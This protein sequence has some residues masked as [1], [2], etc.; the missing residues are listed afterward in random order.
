MARPIAK[1]VTETPLMKQY[2]EMKQKHPD[3][4]L[5]FHVGDFTRRSRRMP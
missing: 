3:A 2:M 5:L 1:K 4:V